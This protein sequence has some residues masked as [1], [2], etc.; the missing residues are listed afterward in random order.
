[1]VCARA[2]KI[3]LVL[4]GFLLLSTDAVLAQN[5]V[6]NPSFETGGATAADSWYA[7]QNSGSAVYSI[8]T[9]P[10]HSGAR[11]ARMDVTQ[12]GDTGICSNR[13][14]VSANTSYGVSVWLSATVGRRAALRVIEWRSD[15]T[16]MADK[17]VAIS[18]GTASGWDLL[19][20]SFV[21]G[22]ST[23]FVEVR[24]MQSVAGTAG[25]GTFFWDDVNLSPGDPQLRNPSFEL[26]TVTTADSWAFFQNSGSATFSIS[27]STVRTGSRA[28][29]TDVTQ[30]GD[31]G[32]VSN[33]F[34][35]V[36]NQ[37][38]MVSAWLKAPLG[39]QASLRV[40]EWGSDLSV[41]ADRT[42]A[43]SSGATSDWESLE[44][45]FITGADTR[46]LEIRLMNNIA[47]SAGTGTFYWDDVSFSGLVGMIDALVQGGCPAPLSPP[48]CKETGPFY[49]WTCWQKTLQTSGYTGVNLYRDAELSVDFRDASN[50]L[51]RSNAGFWDC[52]QGSGE[53]F[54]IRTTLPKGTYTWQAHCKRR[55]GA[56]TTG[57]DCATDPALNGASFLTG[58]KANGTFM[59]QQPT[60][61]STG[62]DR[63]DRGLLTLSGTHRFL[64]KGNT[65]DPF[66]W[67]ADTAWAA[68]KKANRSGDW[69]T[70]LNTRK[71]Q[72]VSVVLLGTSPK[73]AN[74]EE[75]EVFGKMSPCTQDS[76]TLPNNC[77]FWLPA[78][79]QQYEAKIQD[80]NAQGMVV[81]VAGIM[82]P[83]S[84]P[85]PNFGSP[86]WLGVFAR[87]L[88][89]RLA[90]HHVIF[91]PGFD[92][93]I[94]QAQPLA[95]SVGSAIRLAAPAHLITYHGG[96][97]STC[98]N[99][100]VPL[101]TQAWH[102]F[103]L[104][105]SG[106][107]T[108][109]IA[110][111]TGQHTNVC[112][113]LRTYPQTP[114][115]P[116]E[117]IG[118]CVTRR[119]REMASTLYG[120]SPLKAVVNGESVYDADPENPQ[121][122]PAP[123]NR[124]FLRQT[125]YLTT[126]SGSFGFTYGADYF[127]LWNSQA[128]QPAVLTAELG[129]M[130]TMTG[131]LPPFMNHS[132]WDLQRLGSIFRS[133]PNLI[134]DP[135]RIL[136][137]QADDDKKMTYAHTS[138][139]K[140]NLAYLPN[141]PIAGSDPGNTKI[142]LDLSQLLPV[143][144]CTGK[145]SRGN[146]IW[147]A[148]WL[149][150]ANSNSA[151]ALPSCQAASGGFEFTKPVA[152]PR[153]EWVLSIDSTGAGSAIVSDNADTN[154]LQLW[155]DQ[156][157]G[158]SNLSGQVLD[159][160]GADVSGVVPLSQSTQ[161]FVRRKPKAARGSDGN[162]L[163]VWESADQDGSMWGIFGRQLDPDGQPLGAEFQVNTHT[164]QDQAEPAVAS[165]AAGTAVVVWMSFDQDGD[166]GGI[167]GQMYGSDGN[168]ANNEFR[169]N[170]TTAGHQSAPLVGMSDSGAF[171][172][173]WDSEGPNGEDLGIFA[174][175]F[176]ALGQQVGTELLVTPGSSG[177]E[178][179]ADLEVDASGGFVISWFDYDAAANLNGV[180]SRTY[181]SAG[182]P[183]N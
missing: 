15:F 82:E 54:R 170:T 16:V 159:A 102:D 62:N 92:D 134:P 141:H 20:G 71:N 59:V 149:N 61:G 67:L 153:C 162:F 163:A 18:A 171:V 87:N 49:Q 176:D 183:Q 127:S 115:I 47:G 128:S 98:A 174:Q 157:D 60:G 21:T 120:A 172:V 4:C 77:S 9:A 155:P 96:G 34:E 122:S 145:D 164:D 100:I 140:Y 51:V 142:R 151:A 27:T 37:G 124:S 167:Y 3:G 181:D 7:C 23:S 17:T 137:Q 84:Y 114:G 150:P 106:H 66:F 97:S 88:A 52:S 178:V 57:K 36:P 78:Y 6:P 68:V 103:H 118:Q 138:N 125:A 180:L 58:G 24:L 38:Y 63:Y 39:Q 116:N 26:G 69:A 2:F 72:G 8:A 144:N 166:R 129:P 74:I 10:V 160:S 123:E 13:I 158:A 93:S 117:T 46:L 76:N 75:A 112:D 40:I 95:N 5:L 143:F 80:A 99:Y 44:G 177:D 29:R 131:L 161:Q 65:A 19:Q 110:I 165:S 31:L 81:V 173:A 94:A 73:F 35:V 33:R 136:N 107:C 86:L 182:Q 152:C 43:S 56:P 111:L 79:W 90:G 179:L 154:L 22:A 25:T 1:M 91:S 108:N 105:Q 89:A 45:G 50:T 28:I 64:T 104:F 147:T 148:L 55:T 133:R 101:Q 119:A 156:T 32:V 113:P 132:A 30:S 146:V 121:P 11:G 85:S 169:V 139:Y 168:R 135:A 175:R 70:Y 48:A 109:S 53:V 41:K 126:L 83:F 130:P 14:A 42:L 12:S